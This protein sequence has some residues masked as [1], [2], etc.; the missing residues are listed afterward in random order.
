MNVVAT[1]PGDMAQNLREVATEFGELAQ[2]IALSP[3]GLTI[4]CFFLILVICIINLKCWL[5]GKFL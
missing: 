5:S 1:G 3:I 2:I 4:K